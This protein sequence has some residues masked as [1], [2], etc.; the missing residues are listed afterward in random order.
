MTREH[1]QKLKE[2]FAGIITVDYYIDKHIVI[3]ISRQWYDTGIRKVGGSGFWAWG[4]FVV[5]LWVVEK[6]DVEIIHDIDDR[7]SNLSEGIVPGSR[8]YN[9]N[10]EYSTFGAL[11]YKRPQLTT[12]TQDYP[13]VFINVDYFCFRSFFRR[14]DVCWHWYE[15]E[16]GLNTSIC[17]TCRLY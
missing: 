9:E 10:E 3:T 7:E 5:L 15:L 13:T 6:Q 8:V 4:C 11:L 14:E 1:L 16:M 12:T 17:V 2:Y